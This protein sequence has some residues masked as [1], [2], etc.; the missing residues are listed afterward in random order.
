MKSCFFLENS[1]RHSRKSD[2]TFHR[3]SITSQKLAQNISLMGFPLERVSRVTEKIG[4]DD[5]KVMFG[6]KFLKLNFENNSNVF[7]DR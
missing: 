5:K 2:Q 7:T 4:K 6:F 1:P 3:L